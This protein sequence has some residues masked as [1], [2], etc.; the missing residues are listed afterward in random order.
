MDRKDIADWLRRQLEDDFQN[1][2]QRLSHEDLDDFLSE[3]VKIHECESNAGGPDVGKL[4]RRLRK[5]KQEQQRRAMSHVMPF[6]LG[7]GTSKFELL[8]PPRLV[9]RPILRR[10]LRPATYKRYVVPHIEDMH[11]EYFQC[12]AAG[13]ERGARWAVVRAHLYAIPT[14]AWALI[15]R[16]IEWIRA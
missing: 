4:E 9:Y 15:A 16:V 5:L 6:A 12:L 8:R 10:L 3:A 7:A 14:G 11:A 13:D 1:L 2:V